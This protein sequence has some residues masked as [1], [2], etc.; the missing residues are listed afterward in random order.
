LQVDTVVRNAANTATFGL[1]DKADAAIDATLG[2][3]GGG[4]WAH[5]YQAELDREAAR[6]V[7]DSI[8]RGVARRLGE[9]LGIGLDMAGGAEGGVAWSEGLPNL[10]KGKLGEALSAGKT[11]LKGDFPVQF[12]AIKRLTR[13][14]TRTDHATA[15][16]LW[17]EA[18]FGPKARLLPRQ[19]QAQVELGPQYRVD[20]WLPK[21][22]GYLGGGTAGLGGLLS[23]GQ[24]EP[25]R[26]AQ[27]FGVAEPGRN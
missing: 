9:T 10:A 5:R 24:N 6:T 23:A 7:Y 12:Q 13:G 22:V 27:G 2:V 1:A 20:W 8:H 14:Y 11:I 21:H 16:G 17:V 15:K 4:D 19:N 18:K 3:G 25:K 26:D